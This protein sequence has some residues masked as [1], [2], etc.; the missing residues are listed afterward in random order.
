MKKWVVAFLVCVSLAVLVWVGLRWMQNR[1]VVENRSG[2][3]ITVLKISIAGEAIVFENLADGAEVSSAFPI[4]TDDHFVVDGRLADGTEIHGGFGYVT[5]GMYRE[6]ARFVIK[7][8]GEVTF[9]QGAAA[10]SPN[11]QDGF[12]KG[13]SG[14]LGV[15]REGQ[16]TYCVFVDRAVK[17]QGQASASLRCRTAKAEGAAV[18]MQ[19]FRADE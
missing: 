8:G 5:N 15:V 11:K 7:P 17:H 1:L 19:T 10:D 16:E 13:W 6:R 2:Q 9:S 12:P 14:I 4:K 18:L 3:T